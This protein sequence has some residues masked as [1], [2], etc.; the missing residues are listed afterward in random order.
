MTGNEAKIFILGR[1][2]L[3]NK[4]Y[5]EVEDYKEAL[6]EAVKAL[7]LQEKIFKRKTEL[8]YKEGITEEEKVEYYALVDLTEVDE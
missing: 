5:P 7:E 4:N 3:I 6:Q 2:D 1:I 8:Y